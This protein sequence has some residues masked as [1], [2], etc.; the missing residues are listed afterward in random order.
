MEDRIESLRRKYK[1]FQVG[2][3]DVLSLIDEAKAVLEEVRKSG[4]NK[5]AEE[6]EDILIDLEFSREE[7]I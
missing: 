1:A 4:K 3:E 7:M 5:L 6:I 2:R